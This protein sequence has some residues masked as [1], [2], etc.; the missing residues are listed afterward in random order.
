MKKKQLYYS[1]GDVRNF[2]IDPTGWYPKSKIIL[3]DGSFVFTPFYPGVEKHNLKKFEHSIMPLII[4]KGIHLEN[5]PSSSEKTWEAE[6]WVKARVDSKYISR[7]ELAPVV[8]ISPLDYGYHV[9][10][11]KEEIE[12]AFAALNKDVGLS[13]KKIFSGIKKYLKGDGQD[14]GAFGDYKFKDSELGKLSAITDKAKIDS[15]FKKTANDLQKSLN[16]KQNNKSSK[17]TVNEPSKD[18]K[19][20]R[21]SIAHKIAHGIA[22]FFKLN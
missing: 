4:A 17:K 16:L 20:K 5:H 10:F 2:G 21:K 18:E 19:D 14:Q 15:D 3:T 9:S 12:Q 6:R 7:I 1:L 22:K 13:G 8:L 11:T